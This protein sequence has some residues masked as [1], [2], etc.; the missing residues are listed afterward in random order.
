MYSKL[1]LQW[2][3]IVSIGWDNGTH[4]NSYC[5]G[6]IISRFAILTAGHCFFTR[7]IK[8]PEDFERRDITK[9]RLGD[10]TLNDDTNELNMAKTYEINTVIGHP[11]YRNSGVKYDIAVIITKE[12]IQFNART[13]PVCLPNEAYNSTDKYANQTAK[14]AGFGYFDGTNTAS[15]ELRGANFKI[16]SEV[17][18]VS[19]NLYRPRRGAQKHF[20]CAGNLVSQLA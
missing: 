8:L 13:K 10:Q 17:D 16:L 6:S 7:K 1:L 5:T 14:F 9:V 12:P 4:W 2:P 20:F 15:D 18:C 11:K 3:W 19:Q